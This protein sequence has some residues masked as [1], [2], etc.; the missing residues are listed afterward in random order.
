[1]KRPVG[2]M[3]KIKVTITKDGP[4]AY[5]FEPDSELWDESRG[6]FI[7]SKTR[8]D[9]ADHDYHLLEFAIDDQTGE[10][11]KFPAV[12]HDAMWVAEG[13][14]EPGSRN[15]PDKD[16]VCNYECMEPMSVSPNRNRLFV[17]NDNARKEH[18]VFTINFTKTGEDPCDVSR[19]VSWDPGSNNQNGG[20]GTR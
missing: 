2:N 18:W 14:E 6:E 19:F 13:H 15:C 10:G 1:M 3:H 12:P 7:F 9:M 5:R 8:H 16:T 4:D 17:R 20:S 11:L